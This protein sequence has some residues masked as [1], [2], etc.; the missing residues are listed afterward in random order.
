MTQLVER[1]LIARWRELLTTYNQIACALERDLQDNHGIGLSEFEVLDR[2][3]E[4][5]QAKMRMHDLATDIY[6]SQSALSRTVARLE[7]AGRVVR[8]MC[9]DDRRAIFVSPTE[10]GR[11]LRDEAR[12]THRAV[13]AQHIPA[14]D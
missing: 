14:D 3:V 2:L 10:P 7:R 9:A 12:E 5:G 11:Q 13:L 1:G 8:A 6:L 4:S